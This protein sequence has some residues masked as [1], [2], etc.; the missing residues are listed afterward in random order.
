MKNIIKK[1]ASSIPIGNSSYFSCPKCHKPNKLGITR[2]PDVTIYQC[3]SASC[4]L[5]GA[6]K[7]FLTKDALT[8]MIKNK[9]ST[10]VQPFVLPDYFIDG[11]ASDDSIK[12]AQK[13]N[14]LSGYSKKAFKTLYDPK[15]HR[16]VFL[17]TNLQG[18]V[19]GA[20][21]RALKTS[22][23]PKAHIYVGSEKTPWVVGDTKTLVVVE[24]ILSAIQVFN[25]GAT[26]L[27][28]SGTSIKLDYL[29]WFKGYDTIIICLDF[30]AVTKSFDMKKLLDFCA[31]SVIIK[32]INKDIKDMNIKEVK[33]L[34]HD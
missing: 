34:L 25:A 27:A 7:S 20:M 3:F 2:N 11:L 16:Q 8:S 32:L 4:G 33:E 17:H 6:I 28:L 29:D 31:K 21:G 1:L 9:T 5:K 19:V 30:D 18:D 13:Y 12:L 24:D 15:L 23:K 14:L 22:Q 10:Y 26:G